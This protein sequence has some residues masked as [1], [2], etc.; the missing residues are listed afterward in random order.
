MR[1]HKQD[2]APAAADC[3]RERPA[4][5]NRWERA[6][7]QSERH[8]QENVLGHCNLRRPG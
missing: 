4:A 5:H 3:L 8:G 2:L 7:I 1:C 6:R